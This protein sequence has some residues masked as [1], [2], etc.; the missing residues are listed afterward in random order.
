MAR[1]RLSCGFKVVGERRVTATTMRADS[2]TRGGTPRTNPF[3]RLRRAFSTTPYPPRS[4]L[5]P[6]SPVAPVGS[7]SAPRPAQPPR[8]GRALLQ[9][10]K[11]PSPGQYGGHVV[12]GSKNRP[13]DG[14]GQ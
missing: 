1:A 9:R 5:L 2:C 4:P 13:N 12:G 14:T 6:I 8:R 10:E 11:T 7:G 3:I